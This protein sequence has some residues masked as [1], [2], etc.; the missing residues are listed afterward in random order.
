MAGVEEQR[1]NVILDLPDV[2]DEAGVLLGD[3]F[4]VETRIVL[5]EASNVLQ[6]PTNALF[7]SDGQWAVYLADNGRAR[8][9]IIQLGHQTPQEAEVISGVADGAWVILVLLPIMVMLQVI[10]SRIRVLRPVAVL[11]DS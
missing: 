9:A 4:R 1:V 2:D 11:L 8:L 7:R 3:A 10:L 5:W 6:V